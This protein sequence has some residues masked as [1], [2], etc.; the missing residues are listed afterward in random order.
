MLGRTPV[1]SRKPDIGDRAFDIPRAAPKNLV[2]PQVSATVRQA[3]TAATGDQ[4]DA[5]NQ[6]NE[7]RA[8]LSS[9]YVAAL[10][11]VTLMSGA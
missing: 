6:S 4:G 7:N 2:D 10:Q 11:A 1:G 5:A 3:G 9:L 8:H